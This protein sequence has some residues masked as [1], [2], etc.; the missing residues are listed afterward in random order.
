[1]RD[2]SAAAEKADLPKRDMRLFFTVR[3]MGSGSKR[4]AIPSARMFDSWAMLYGHDPPTGHDGVGAS[5]GQSFGRL[6]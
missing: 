3:H 2:G 5:M 6:V 4:H 1:L